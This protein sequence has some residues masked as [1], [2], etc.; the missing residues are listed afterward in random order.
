MKR[1]PLLLLSVFLVSVSHAQTAAINNGILYVSGSSDIFF[2]GGNFTNTSS[3]LT[4]N[5]QLYIQGN[6]TNDQTPATVGTGTLILNGSSAQMVNGSQ[7]FRT[8][9]LNT[10]NGAG[11]TLNNNLNVSG[12]HVF[13]SGLI[14]TSATPGYLVYESGSSYSGASDARHVNGWVKKLGTDNFTFPVGDAN[15]LRQIAVSALS[16]TAEFNA[17]YNGVTPNTT[18]IQS[19]LISINPNEHW[20]LNQVSG[21][22]AQAQVTLNWDDNKVAFPYSY[23]P[24]IRSAQYINGFWTSTGGT[25]TGNGTIGSIT[26]IAL[27]TFGEMSIGSTTE[28][29]SLVFISVQAKRYPDHVMIA[30]TTADETNV[31]SIEVERSTN[32]SQFT[33]IAILSPRNQPGEQQYT[34][35]DRNPSPGVAYYRIKSIDTDGQV[36]YSRIVAVSQKSRTDVFQLLTNPVSNS[37][38]LITTAA[39]ASYLYQLVS[40]DGKTIQSGRANHSG[41]NRINIPLTSSVKPG[42]Y[43]LVLSLGSEKHTLKTVVH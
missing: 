8:Y 5:G 23:L 16:A 18:N 21:S 26:S 33:S 4:N 30:W 38:Q 41:G 13:T 11:I 7:A 31:K 27:S 19:P 24:D 14:T 22:G 9:N 6:F 15:Y 25:A 39:P 43:L 34:N 42:N 20:L 2:A 35:M 1:L 28:V 10:N 3:A 36:K 29:L 17:R 40:A 37:I 12:S 32:G